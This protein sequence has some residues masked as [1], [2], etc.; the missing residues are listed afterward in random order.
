MTNNEGGTNNEEFRNVAI[1]DRVNTT[2]AVWMG[3][4][5]NCCQCHTHKYDPL[6]QAEYFQLFAIF[7]NSADADLRDESPLLEIWSDQQKQQ[8]T[9]WQAEIAKLKQVITTPTA[10]TIASQATWEKRYSREL[11]WQVLSPKAVTLRSNGSASIS[12]EGQIHVPQPQKTDVYTVDLSLTSTSS[13]KATVNKASRLTGIRLDVLPHNDLPGHGP[14]HANGNFV[15][16]RVQASI[17][18]PGGQQMSGRYIR[19]ENNGKAKI[20]SLAEVQVYRGTEN[21][22]LKG[23]AKQSS[24]GSVGYAKLAIDGN[25]DGD[26]QKRSTTHTQTEDN[27]WWELDLQSSQPVDRIEI[28]NRTDNGLHTGLKDFRIVLLDENRKV[29]WET[30]VAKSPNPNSG[31]GVSGARGITF[32]AAYA[33]F[34]QDGFAAANVLNTKE[35][36]NSGW[37]IAPHV[38]QSHSLTLIPQAPLEVPMGSTLNIKI[39]QLSKHV[40]HTLGHFQ[41][42]VTEDERASEY[43]TTP[44]PIR[45]ILDLP[46]SART[47]AQ[48]ATLSKYYL[49]ITPE[50]KEQRTKLAQLQKQLAEIKPHT[51][52]PIMRELAAEKQRTTNIQLRGNYLAKGAE[53]TAGVP[54]AFH[55]LPEGVPVDRLALARWL[56]DEKNPLTARVIANRYW[57]AIFGQGIV[58]TSEEFGSQGDLPTHPE[59]LDYLATELVRLNWDMKAFL[60]VLVTSATYRQSSK[61]TPEVYAIDPA[62]ILMARGPRFR[63]SAEM[64]RDSALSVSGLLETKMFGMPA[65][66]PQPKLGL[67]AAFGSKTDWETSTGVDRYRRGIYTTWRRSNPYPSMA[68]FD[69]PSREVCIVRR[70][71]T[72]TPLQ[73]LVT[74][75]DPV[76]VEA[77]QALARKMVEGASTTVEKAQAGFR[78]C[79]A[80]PPS[81]AE[82]DQLV[83]LYEK[84]HLQFKD[85]PDRAMQMAT[86][87]LGPLP[88]DA[89]AIEMAAWTVVANVLLNLDEMLM[90]R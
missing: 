78:H 4:T 32:A 80:R 71:R 39:E 31:Y 46:N 30:T 10:E 41:I 8:K 40:N 55:P 20:L 49:T 47:D 12:E 38:A 63:L 50:F 81:Q 2:M 6:T 19:I 27:P 7:N 77:A 57:E 83:A 45:A 35:P 21:V 72:N 53:V 87:P 68:T 36:E 1:V 67:S 26:Y 51:T 73:A 42:A 9:A 14:G 56:V 86:D 33:D 88:A 74:L 13:D 16:T 82:L 89:D 52:V 11:A 22:A 25:T 5:M 48:G 15:V 59:L 58:K 69:A 76:Y 84:A 37:A 3:T 62:N 18:P 75:N 54:A 34:S 85:N 61:V 70:D 44:A 43:A 60:K 17:V 29:V 90:K 79:L 66:P 65:K 23:V 28:W 64:I 24:L